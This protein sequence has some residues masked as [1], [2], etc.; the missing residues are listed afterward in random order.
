MLAPPL[1]FTIVVPNLNGAATLERALQSLAAQDYPHKQIIVADGGSTDGS[2]RILREFEG[3]L[4]AVLPGPDGGQVEG[5]NR[6][7]KLATG[8]VYGWLCADDE[9]CEGALTHVAGLFALHPEAAVMAGASERIYPDQTRETWRVRAD[10]WDVLGLL[11][12]LDQPSVFWRAQWH[13]NAGDLDPSYSLAF[14]WEFWCRLKRAGARL[15]TTPRVLSRYHFSDSN[16][17]SLGGRRH[18]D[19]G[20]RIV[21]KYGPAFGL[22]ARAYRFLFDHFDMHGCMDPEPSASRGRMAAYA[23]TRIAL[24]LLLGLRALRCYNWHFAALQERR[25]DWWSTSFNTAAVPPSALESRDADGFGVLLSGPGDP[26][27]SDLACPNLVLNRNRLA[28]FLDDFGQDGDVLDF[29]ALDA[30]NLAAALELSGADLPGVDAALALRPFR[31]WEYVWIFKILGLRTGGLEVLDI[32]GAASHLTAMSALAGN[33]VVSL[34]DRPPAV[35]A[36]RRTAEFLGVTNLETMCEDFA[37]LSRF[38]A[39]RFDRVIICSTLHRLS[40]A[41]QRELLGGAA[42]LVKPGGLVGLTFDYGLPLQGP[43]IAEPYRHMPAR[44]NAEIRSR[45]LQAG[46][47]IAG[48]GE[49]EEPVEGALFRRGAGRHSIAALFLSPSARPDLPSPVP[50]FSQ[51][52]LLS[53]LR[54]PNLAARMYQTASLRSKIRSGRPPS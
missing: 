35:A 53:R 39:A 6:A 46:L 30:F 17:T 8:E 24:R 40:A 36:A 22:A 4:D 29:L 52:S 7:F 50:S 31:L 28:R 18:V 44:S 1:R 12:P 11:N 32:G 26:L 38:E 43:A 20:F 15:L 37:A 3:V 34:D 5:L 16:K 33:Q 41:A 21:R 25:I 51:G 10:A 23:G 42:R 13:R 27:P 48:N 49:L 19:E 47:E 2:I 9:L 14:D 45:Y 54:S